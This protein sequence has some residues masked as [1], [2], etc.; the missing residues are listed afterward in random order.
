MSGTGRFLIFC[1]RESNYQFDSRPF[2]CPYLEL[3]M[4][5]W[6]MQGHFGHLHFKTFPMTLRALKC[7]EIWPLQSR[8]EF[9]KVPEDSNFPLLEVW[10]SP[11][12]LA[13]SGVATLIVFAHPHCFEAWG[14][15]RIQISY[16]L[17]NTR[18]KQC[19]CLASFFYSSPSGAFSCVLEGVRLSIKKLRF[20]YKGFFQAIGKNFK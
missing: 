18:P 20:Y 13:Q 15:T 10:A 12:H 4:F 19:C 11:S 16:R 7:K 8:S 3:Q 5:K 17:H 9:S 14:A 1:G 2:F 6:L